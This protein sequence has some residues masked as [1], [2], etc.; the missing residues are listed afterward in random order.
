MLQRL[1]PSWNTFV[2]AFYWGL[3]TVVRFLLLTLTHWKATGRERVPGEGPLII[4]S[5]HL[6]NA[7]P[8]ILAAGVLGRRIRFMAKIELFSGP[9]SPF[10]KLY[11]AFPVRRFEADVGALLNAERILKAGN[12]IGMFPEGH[13]SPD[14]TFKKPHPG[15]ALIALR[16]GATVLPCAIVGTEV[17]DNPLRLIRRP[18]MAVYVGQPFAVVAVRRPTETQIREMSERIYN[19]I[20]ALLP[21]RY[22]EAYTGSEEGLALANG[23]DRSSE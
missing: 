10:I 23:G 1:K 22:V 9:L 7:D 14:R 17:L 21:P 4:V 18:P 11:G 12:V 13:R 20:A 5:N 6:S 15:T 2:P 16:S 8:G 19:E 3:T